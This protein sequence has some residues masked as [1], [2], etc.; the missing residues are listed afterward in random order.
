MGGRTARSLRLRGRADLL[1]GNYPSAVEAY[2]TASFLEQGNSGIKLEFGIAAALWARA[3]DHAALGYQVALEQMLQCTRRGRIPESL[4]DTALLFDDIP[5]YNQELDQWRAAM[6]SEPSSDWRREAAVKLA[7]VERRL[8]ERRKHIQ[9]LT[10]SPE[11]YLAHANESA[12]SLEL[13]MNAAVEDWLPVFPRPAIT[14][15]A[16]TALA[17]SLKNVQ[18]DWW[19]ADLLAMPETAR[20]ASALQLL[21][22]AAKANTHGEYSRAAAS[23]TLAE[24]RFR[25]IGNLAG[26][27]RSHLELVYSL[28]LRGRSDDCIKELAAFKGAPRRYVWMEWQ[29]ELEAITCRTL[30][31]KADVIVARETAYR[32]I[33]KTGY[34]GLQL[35]ALSFLTENCVCFG[36]RLRV[37]V[38][39]LQG[40]SKYWTLPMPAVR[41]Y[42][43]YANM[44]TSAHNSGDR[45]AAVALL[46][47]TTRVLED[48]PNPQLLALFLTELGKWE[49]EIGMNAE[50][51][52]S[53]ERSS[54]LFGKLN[55]QETKGSRRTAEILRAEAETSGGQPGVALAR[56]EEITKGSSFPFTTFP[57]IERKRLISAMGDAFL[58]LGKL[59]RA[60][61]QYLVVVNETRKD[62]KSV[63]GCA[64]RDN[65]QHEI[66]SA[67]RGL[68]ELDI[69]RGDFAQALGDWESFRGGRLGDPS[70][71]AVRTS[72]GVALLVY[73]FLPGGL[74]GWL[75]DQH[76]VRSHRWIDAKSTAS[77]ASQLSAL[78]ADPKS[79]LEAVAASARHLNALLIEPFAGQLATDNFLVIDADGPLAGIP[80]AALQDSH[81]R[82]LVERFP[83]SQVAGWAEVTSRLHGREVDYSRALVLGE[84]A[85]GNELASQYP[86][87]IEARLEAQQLKRL[88]PGNTMFFEGEQATLDAAVRYLPN[89]TLF[90]FAGHGVSYGTFGA[91]LLAPSPGDNV[92]AQ[93]LTADRIAGMNLKGLQLAVL[94][95][96]SSGAGEESGT[97]DLDSLVHGFL[98]AG[99]SRVVAS[100][101]NISSRETSRLMTRFYQL[102]LSSKRPAAALRDAALEIRKN[103]STAHPYYWASFQVFGAP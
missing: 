79:E 82:A 19:L 76:G 42:G 64:Q 21:A 5:L 100:R 28:H 4:F 1:V 30:T 99:T 70:R 10:S 101:W 47:E 50:A 29:A 81:G 41:G 36:S 12:G 58:A 67:W 95:A 88:L 43:F 97:V 78:A 48:A 53:F 72:E 87:L 57:Y 46:R 3:D 13:A 77:W 20:S 102:I 62:L 55:M 59:D 75:V 23:A 40:L 51:A 25:K 8:E 61:E 69:R 35:R 85:L 9:E 44:G 33:T 14:T 71:E 54:V 31:R 17:A 18:L 93:L 7:K 80:W 91:L 22:E 73:A 63:Q 45:E 66:E 94:A 39:G 103:P 86:R 92:P 37:W 24:Q 84:P 11:S 49:M 74:S 15:K 32:E 6:Q 38:R 89:A 65:A 27:L 96:C 90:H 2:R 56:L 52:R 83:L 16:L 60:S 68:T 26:A 98:E 34:E